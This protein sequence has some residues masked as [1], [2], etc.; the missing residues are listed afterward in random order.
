M[1]KNG[2]VE[3]FE[4]LIVAFLC[5]WCSYAGA[6]LAGVSRYQYPPSVRIIR[7]MCSGRIDPYMVFRA[8]HNGADGVLVAGCHIGDCHYISG[9]LHSKER[10]EQVSRII[11]KSKIPQERFRLAWVSASE[12]K[13]FARLIEEFTEELRKLGP[14]SKEVLG[15]VSSIDK[16]AAAENLFLDFP[17][18]W[19]T[20][21]VDILAQ[22]ENV[23]GEQ[24]D[25]EQL[26]D[27]AS[28]F[29]EM[30]HLKQLILQIITNKPASLFTL[31][32]KLGTPS[33]EVFV[34]LVE[35]KMEGLVDIVGFENDSP[36]YLHRGGGRK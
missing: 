32:E 36:V 10:M 2:A 1:E 26:K 18:R 30:E 23:F 20:A 12:G 11:E 16:V 22:E 8:F 19:L 4:P 31:S 25:P 15:G 5:N 27:V 17:V 13:I 21:K 33:K 3:E 24:L 9:N 28:N 29:F 34:S 14:L 35:L 7:V 6:D